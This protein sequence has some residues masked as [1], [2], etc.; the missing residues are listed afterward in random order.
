MT[1]LSEVQPTRG[2]HRRTLPAIPSWVWFPLGVYLAT[3]VLLLIVAGGDSLVEHWSL[4]HEMANWDG[5]WYLKTAA[6]G[7]PHQI[8]TG[9]GDYST[10][11]FLPLYPAL[12]WLLS[13]VPAL[14]DFGAGL[15]ISLLCG[16]IAT[17]NMS[18]LAA[19]WWDEAASRRAILFFCLFPGTIVFSMDYAEG[20]QLALITFAL[21]SL[22]DRKWVRGGLSGGLATAVSPVALAFI[23]TAVVAAGLEL[24]RR[25]WRNR[26]AL[27]SLAA[28]ILSPIGIAGFGLFLWFW[29]GT[30]MASYTAQHRA[31]QETS[32]P[33]AV[34]RLFI[35]VFEQVF[36]NGTVGTHGPGGI[37]LNA[38]NGILGTF[39]L[40]FGMWL[41]WKHRRS[42]HITSLIW[43]LGVAFLAATSNSTPPNARMLICAFP[44]L[45]AIGA[46]VVGRRR[47][48]A[49]LGVET[50]LLVVMSILT[51]YG[52]WLR[53]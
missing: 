27:K 39:V 20:L 14:S 9:A 51:Y 7:Y 30:P 46:M 8:P 50:L 3:R 26:E 16:A 1:T 22:E 53:P 18:R 41:L 28:P 52:F 43:T 25:G 29:D 33:L 12:M 36:L 11:G 38:I 42:V 35:H 21:L 37:D 23:P 13:R 47:R 5:Q 4:E 6:F 17:L 49:M 15:T 48:W 40:L 2:L 31:W 45:L 34:P 24:R 32:T 10:L 44:A 19:R